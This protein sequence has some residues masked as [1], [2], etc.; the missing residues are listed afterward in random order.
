MKIHLYYDPEK[1]LR[2]SGA[3][4]EL[5]ESQEN[6]LRG[7]EE[8]PDRKLHY[9]KY[10]YINRSKEGKL[11]F[12]RNYKAIDEELRSCGF[13]LIAETDFKKTTAEILEIY[14]RRDT[15]EKSFDNLKNELDMK[16]M[17][18][19]SSETAKGKLF[20]SFLS[21]IVN[22]Y[23]LRQLKPYMQKNSLTLRSILLELDKMKTI[24]YPGS[25]EPRHLNPLT[26]RQ[27]DIYELLEIPIP[28][29]IG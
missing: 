27:G 18:S 10:F 24:L 21:L 3:L 22:A 2:E 6:D 19:Q 28:D 7:M 5:L 29:C 4:Y 12:V 8:P 17:R 15:I 14:R 16:R 25:R 23:L 9:D 13:F 26:K 20:V 11:G 1:A